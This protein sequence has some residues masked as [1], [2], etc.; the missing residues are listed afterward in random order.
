MTDGDATKDECENVIKAFVKKYSD[1]VRD[2]RNV[3]SIIPGVGKLIVKN[4]VAGV[5]FDK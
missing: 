4:R 3:E 2:G 5:I 1:T